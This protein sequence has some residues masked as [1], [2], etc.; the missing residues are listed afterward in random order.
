MNGIITGFGLGLLAMWICSIIYRR[1]HKKE[2]K[3]FKANAKA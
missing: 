1:T 2:W 3:K